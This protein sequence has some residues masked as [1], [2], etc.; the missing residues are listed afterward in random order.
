VQL[1]EEFVEVIKK[2]IGEAQG[3][4]P[5]QRFVSSPVFLTN[6]IL[7]VPIELSCLVTKDFHTCCV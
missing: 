1:D 5:D 3:G 6:C 4:K 7:F 2:E